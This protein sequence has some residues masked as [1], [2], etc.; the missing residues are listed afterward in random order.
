MSNN[1]RR[2]HQQRSDSVVVPSAPSSS[3]L[4]AAAAADQLL[5]YELSTDENQNVKTTIR[6]QQI[7]L[8]LIIIIITFLIYIFILVFVDP[9]LAYFT[10]DQSDTFYPYKDDTVPFWAVGLYGALAPILIV[11]A[12]E[13]LRRINPVGRISVRSTI[14]DIYS[15]LSLFAMGIAMTVVLT[16]IGNKKLPL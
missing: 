14:V 8:D 9:K 10:C 11:L 16:E 2:Q 1:Q 13:F 4:E 7:I 3:S 12:T 5:P 15:F 6:I